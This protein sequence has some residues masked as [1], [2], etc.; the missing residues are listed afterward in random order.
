MSEPLIKHTKF[1][2]FASLELRSSTR[3]AN[4]TVQVKANVSTGAKRCKRSMRDAHLGELEK[5]SLPR[6]DNHQKQ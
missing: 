2:S 1:P 4:A 3:A 5:A 6:L